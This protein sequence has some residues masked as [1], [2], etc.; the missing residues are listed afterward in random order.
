MIITQ[1]PLRISFLGGGT[2]FPEFYAAEPGCVLSA[3]IDKFVYVILKR[4]YD[5]RIRVGY[6]RTEM[7]E[8]VGDVQHD[9]VR[10]ALGITGIDRG[11]EVATMADI[12]SEG[13]GLGSSSSVS[14]G[15]L[16]AMWVYGGHL[17]G[18]RQLAEGACRIELERLKRP[19]GKQDQFAVAFG[20]LNFITFDA[21]G[22]GVE[23]AVTEAGEGAA[24]GQSCAAEQEG[25][26]REG[27]R[28][29]PRRGSRA[30]G[31]AGNGN[32]SGNPH[33][34]LARRLGERL[35]LFNTGETRNAAAVLTEQRS[36]I[37]DRRPLLRAMAEQAR[38]GR[39]AL[40]EGRLDAIGE[41]MADA[42]EHKKRLADG[43]TNGNIDAMYEAARRAGAIGGKVAGAGGGGFLMLFCPPAHQ[44]A[45]RAA[46]HGYDELEFS[47]EPEGTLVLMHNRRR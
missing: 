46:L 43:I 10:E 12:P 14:V 45:V 20:G 1:T 25:G 15:L 39:I 33:E 41:L 27:H 24:V 32:G 23:P 13:S 9:L 2:D 16:H 22:I 5:D 28:A 21:H 17:P 47:L 31:G 30:G 8:R 18:R 7:V 34:T 29:R 4:R 11:I 36:N 38:Q 35:M 42:W 40:C 44:P 26:V 6:T 19:I 37:E 3:T